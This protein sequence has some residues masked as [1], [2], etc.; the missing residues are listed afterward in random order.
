MSSE[1]LDTGT[2]YTRK[3][4]TYN[5]GLTEVGRGKPMGELLR[6]Y[7]HPIALVT[8]AG[9]TPKPVRVLGEDLIL[10]RDGAGRAGLVE[11]RCCHRGTTLYY[12]RVEERGI[13]CCYHGW[14]FDTQG[15]CLE[16]PCEPEGGLKTRSRAPALV[17][18]AGTLRADLRLY[19]PA[20]EEAGASAL[21]LPGN[22]R[23]RR[24]DRSRRQ[25]HRFRR[26]YDRALQ[27]AST[28][29]KRAG[30]VPRSHSAWRVQRRTVRGAD[31][32]HAQGKV[33]IFADRRQDDLRARAR[34]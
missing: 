17:S 9:T 33:G 1:A 25:Q 34:R 6:R 5:A 8:D 4:P 30:C 23:A 24:V 16:Q 14:L 15:R 19:G 27:L 13:R 11:A 26:R 7:W 12:G 20:G 18:R 3:A 28:L 31:G 29:R 2:G 21:R 22:A 32:H 10:F